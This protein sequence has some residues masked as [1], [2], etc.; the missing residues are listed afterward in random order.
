MNIPF[1][2]YFKRDR[3]AA[4]AVA[5]SPS[6][7]VAIEKP[8]GERLGKT[9]VP[10]ASR[11]VLGANASMNFP[12]SGDVGS[13]PI[14]FAA[15]PPPA[16]ATPALPRKVSLGTGG[17]LSA[18]GTLGPD[19]T[20]TLI[21]ERKIAIPLVDLLSQIPTDLLRPEAIDPE[22]RVLFPATEVERGMSTGR[23]TASLRSLYQQAPEVFSRPVEETDS[24]QVAL[25]LGKVLEQFASFQV[26]VDQ[27]CDENLPQ[28]ETPFLQVALEDSEKFGTSTGPVAR[29]EPP[30]AVAGG[31]DPGRTAADFLSPP[32]SITPGAT[33]LPESTPPATTK[34]SP[35]QISL[36]GSTAPAMINPP[37][38]RPI[39]LPVPAT[40][41]TPA[42]SAAAQ[43]PPASLPS[44]TAPAPRPP[45]RINLS[46]NGTG[47]SAPERV[48][49]S[50]GPPVP[51]SL[52]TSPPAS[53]SPPAASP[54]SLR[55]PP[56][57]D[58]LRQG[59]ESQTQ[60]APAAQAQRRIRLSLREV[61]RAIPPFQISGPSTDEIA[62]SAQ[63]Q[64]SAAIIEP[65]LA[66]GRIQVS[67]EQ[68]Q[69]ALPE[70]FRSRFKIEDPA[71]QIQL[72]LPQVLKN[73]SPESLQ[74]RGDQERVEVTT[75]FETPFSQKAAEDAVRLKPVA[76]AV[77]RGVDPGA[78]ARPAE[79]PR[80]VGGDAGETSASGKTLPGNQ[81]GS[82]LPPTARP[83]A[84]TPP[85]TT[86]LPRPMP[87]P[88][89]SPGRTALQE[90]FDTDEALDAKAVVGRVSGL[91]G[92]QA[93]AI[94]F[95]DG[96]SLAEN[97]PAGYNLEGLCAVAPAIM[98]RLDAQ[99]TDDNL[100]PLTGITLLCAKT[101]VTFFA[102]ENIYLAAL[103]AAG[104][105]LP[106]ETQARLARVTRRLAETYSIRLTSPNA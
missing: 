1:L 33:I 37:G 71:A 22:R 8:A 56:L 93:C 89:A 5:E 9:V 96:L 38:P 47:A 28:V 46:P 73:L 85:A 15:T 76:A 16:M 66:L 58:N 6:Q 36:P 104:G 17:Q 102:G 68:F 100:G 11:M 19:E 40:P 41:A 29:T 91:P 70:E 72:P 45:V 14:G 23:P 88:E 44:A 52:P 18:R 63:L 97:I 69:A 81:P 55:V 10:N 21:K 82:T 43:S 30:V 49:A 13:M 84:S 2:R 3:G 57:V 75:L 94:V 65:Q 87:S 35:K 59:P 106:T 62:E 31:I 32:G 7:I 25:P 86:A 74:T 83:Q 4:T 67:P 34:V 77:S 64:F 42:I 24:T 90:E 95:A 20:T 78:P 39:R 101:P 50:G 60:P 53:P 79:V 103:H 27:V 54:I 92:V 61:V 12:L 99:L 98:K 48:P 51:T 26:R 105:C 80:D